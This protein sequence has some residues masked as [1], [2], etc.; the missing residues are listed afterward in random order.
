MPRRS[1]PAPQEPPHPTEVSASQAAERLGL[2]KQAIGLWCAKPGAPVRKEGTR[3]FVRWPDFARWR[4][5]ELQAAAKKP[6][7]EQGSL[8]DRRA[9]AETRA[10]EIALAR[11]ELALA[12][13]RGE[14]VSV[15][16]FGAA[17][18]RALDL[19]VGRVRAMPSQLEH[20]GPEVERAVEAEAERIIA[21]LQAFDTDVI[22][23]QEPD[24]DPPAEQA[25]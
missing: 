17:L 22:D 18:G 6:E 13:D 2:T 21:E 20:L 24:D 25:A 10:A 3:V 7:A 15:A 23:E 14:V 4:E 8:A 12:R 11:A 9:E 1:P 19:V 16:D 5:Q